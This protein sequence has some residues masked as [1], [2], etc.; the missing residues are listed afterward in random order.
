MGRGSTSE[1]YAAVDVRLERPVAIKFLRAELAADPA[2]RRRFAAEARMAARL[3]HPHVVAV[4][5]TADPPPPE[6]PYIVMELLGGPTL[7]AALATGPLPESVV[8]DMGRQ[9]LSALD[10]ATAMGLVHG[11]IK[12]DNIVATGDGR[13]KVA[14]FGTAVEGACGDRLVVGTPAYLA[15]ERVHGRPATPAG[16]IFS[17]GVLLYEALAGGRPYRTLDFYPWTEA[18]SGALPLPLGRR[19]PEID[20]SL[21]SA[22]DRAVAAEPTRRYARPAELAAAL[23]A[24]GP[25]GR[26]ADCLT[27][28]SL[29]PGSLTPGSLTPGS[30]TPGSLTPSYLTPILPDVAGAPGGP[31]VAGADDGPDTMAVRVI[32]GRMA[33]P[34]RTLAAAARLTVGG[35]LAAALALTVAFVAPTGPA[36]PAPAGTRAA[37]PAISGVAARAV[38]PAG[39]GTSVGAAPPPSGA[40]APAVTDPA[41]LVSAWTPAPAAAAPSPVPT[42]AP[43]IT[44]PPGKGRAA[45]AAAKTP[46]KGHGHAAGPAGHAPHASGRPL[47]AAGHGPAQ[48]PH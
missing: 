13:W 40:D 19:R 18:C 2:C 4:F 8:R 14:D 9:V 44:V 24:G 11:D 22:V 23:D 3:C 33:V 36:V 46:A 1:V 47:A 31:A 20:P 12:P 26:L 10:A 32:G 45:K 38:A 42:A 41:A 35:G 5:D 6:R 43:A 21:A 16:D 37:A 48:P 7:R 29:T 30:L 28:G 15:P 27:P 17:V 25:D 39:A 34:A